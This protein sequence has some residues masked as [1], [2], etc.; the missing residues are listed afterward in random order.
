MLSRSWQ[1]QQ[2]EVKLF[3]ATKT[4]S[5]KKKQNKT[6]QKKKTSARN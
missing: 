1:A 4:D 2:K 3:K 5:F 6:K